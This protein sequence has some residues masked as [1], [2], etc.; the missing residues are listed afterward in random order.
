MRKLAVL[1]GLVL[2]MGL[3]VPAAAGINTDIK[4]SLNTQVYYDQHDGFWAWGKVT[5]EVTMSTGTDGAI[6][7]VIGLGSSKAEQ[8]G[9]FGG[10]GNGPLVASKEIALKVD[11]AYIE[12]N[13]AWIEGTPDV[14]SKIGRFGI[15]YNEWVAELGNRDAVELSNIELGPVDLALAY[16]WVNH[17][18]GDD[19][20]RLTTIRAAANIDVV[21]LSGAVVLSANQDDNS[22][23][24]TDFAVSAKVTPIEGVSLSADFASDG[25]K[26]ATGYKVGGE[27]STIADLTIGVSMWAMEKDFN[28]TYAKRD[29]GKTTAFPDINDKAN[30]RKGFEVKADTTQAG[31]DLGVTYR[32]T[33]DSNDGNKANSYELRVSRDFN[34]IKGSYK[35]EDGDKKNSL[36]TVTVETTVDTPIASGVNLKGTVR[37]PE[38]K[39]VE[40]A[41]D[42]TWTAPNGINLGLHYANYDREDG[43]GGRDVGPKGDADGFVVRASYEISW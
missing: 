33:S 26:E 32:N 38:G 20:V 29:D 5:T 17:D 10:P 28:P 41:A 4:G 9:N 2:V 6:K 8:E 19:D 3:A 21:E 7:A 36:H 12:A 40:F 23:N 16:A 30:E 27:L 35:Y 42:A 24:H 18:A 22:N 34:G 15:N 13:G 39:D 31:F 11:T 43:W 14:T 25:A 37:L 1:M